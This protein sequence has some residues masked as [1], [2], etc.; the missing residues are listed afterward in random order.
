VIH[1]D[2]SW[3]TQGRRLP[4]AARVLLAALAV[5]TAVPGQHDSPSAKDTAPN[6]LMI[7]IDDLNDWIGCLGGHPQAHTPH[8]DALAAES[9]A[10]TNAYC[11]APACNP[12]RTALFSGRAPWKTGLIRNQQVFR[13]LLPDEVLMPRHFSSHGYHA[14]GGGKLLHYIVDARSWDD[15]F[16]SLGRENPFPRTMQPP[17]RPITL[18]RESWMYVEADW[19]PVDATR[20]EYGGDVLVA[21]W[22]AQELSR[23]HE[24]PFFRAAGIYR[25]H[26]PWF[27]PREDFERFSPDGTELPPGYRADD[28]DDVPDA[29]QKLARNRYLPHIREH[30]LWRSGVAAYLASITFADAMVGRILEALDR[31]PHRDS[32]IVVVT[33]DHGWHLGE[34]EH[35]QKFTAWRACARVPLFIRVPRGTPGLPGGT[36]EGARCDAAVSLLDVFPTLTELCGVPAK[37]GVDGKSLVPLLEEPARRDWQAPV[38]T[39][40]G[41]P[42]AFALSGRRFRYIRY[43]EDGGEELYDITRDPHEWNNL[44]HAPEHAARIEA[45]RKLAADEVKVPGT[46]RPPSARDGERSPRR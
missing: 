8:L 18:P 27:L 16:P 6:V 30:D 22:A 21:H 9:M 26:E 36:G 41:Q 17:G 46:S 3:P 19:G 2:G 20:D 10:F 14:A 43:G 31:G 1:D 35:W 40:L 28:L 32:T 11:A 39:Q 33:S 45:F 24:T 23:P 34:K 29:G 42:G 38:R 7:V 15:Y 12:S 44:A 13:D 5:V 37:P 25:P 4:H